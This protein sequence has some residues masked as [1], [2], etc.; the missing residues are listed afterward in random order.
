MVNDYLISY[1]RSGTLFFFNFDCLIWRTTETKKMVF[2]LLAVGIGALLAGATGTY[3][4]T[5]GSDVPHNN[6]AKVDTQGTVNNV[7]ITDFQDQVVI[8]NK[9]I[10]ILLYIMCGIKVIEFLYFIYNHHIGNIKKKY[11]NGVVRNAANA[12]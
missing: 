12:V 10:L 6:G 7:V 9:E 3:F 5:R 8:E 11:E 2:T 4:F 1:F